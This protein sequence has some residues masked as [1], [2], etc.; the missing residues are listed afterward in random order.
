MNE[1]KMISVVFFDFTMLH[2]RKFKTIA[3]PL[4]AN[5]FINDKRPP[6]PPDND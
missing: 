6:K 5:F 2:Q 4:N 1:L 3:A